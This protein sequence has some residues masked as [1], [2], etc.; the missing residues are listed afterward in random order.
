MLLQRVA[1]DAVTA[2]ERLAGMQAQY[3]PSPYIGLWSRL[4]G[5]KREE[6]EVAVLE[7]RVL[8]AT[9]MRGTLHMVSGQDFSR[10]RVASRSPYHVY[11]QM[12]QQLRERGVDVD[13]V[14][15]EIVA[16][17]RQRPLKRVEVR[18]MARHLVPDDLPEWAAWST[19]ALSGDLINLQDDARFGYFGGSRYRLAPDDESEAEGE[20][21]YVATAYFAAFGPATRADLAQWSGRS[22]SSFAAALDDLGLVSLHAEDGRTLLDLPST[23]RPDPDIPAPVRFLPKWDNLLLAY[24]RRERVLPERYRKIVIRKNG[25]VLPTFLVDGLIAGTWEAPLRGP[26]VLTLSPLEPL[27]DDNRAEIEHEG[28]RLL[29]W[30][31]PDTDRRAITWA[32]G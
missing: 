13:A 1:I 10:Y 32:I 29:T 11:T 2:I 6:L 25:D 16:A 26:A 28:E 30:L 14:R 22:V 7:D 12:V 31:R 8:K 23:P 9:L 5:F 20:L 27:S 17:L 24:A 15:E 4:S 3:S 19:V 21:R 18:A